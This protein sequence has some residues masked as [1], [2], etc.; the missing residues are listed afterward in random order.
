MKCKLIMKSKILK[1][2]YPKNP[3]ILLDKEEVQ[4]YIWHLEDINELDKLP[5]SFLSYYVVGCRLADEVNNGGFAQYLSN[6]SIQ[7][8]PYLERCVRAIGNSEMIEI[9]NEFLSVVSKDFDISDIETIAK[10]AYSEELE[11]VLLQLD[12]RFYAFDEK[13]DVEMLAKNY[14]K[15]NLP[16]EKLIFELVKPPVT[17]RRRYFVYN[18]SNISNEEAAEAFMDFIAE[19]S[20]IRFNIEIEKWCGMFRIYAIDSTNSLNLA[21]IF[22]HFD[23]SSYSFGKKE[24]TDRCKILGFKFG[25]GRFKEVHI[26]SCDED[27]WIWRLTISESGFDDNEYE[28]SYYRFCSGTSGSKKVSR[29]CVGDFDD[30]TTNLK[31]IEAIFTKRAET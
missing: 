12:D 2:K 21:E 29:I 9:I 18:K 3:G 14:Y 24:G 8:L 25:G 28:I 26:D 31:A 7:T 11:N 17:D 22:A 27:N 4:S 30:K 6:S 20:N 16:E 13:Y 23:D 15:A 10:A 19:F 5:L 1:L